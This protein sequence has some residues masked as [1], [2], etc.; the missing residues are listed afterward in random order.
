MLFLSLAS[1]LQLSK[2]TTADEGLTNHVF[3]AVSSIISKK[4]A[5]SLPDV[6][7]HGFLIMDITLDILVTLVY[8]VHRIPSSKTMVTIDLK[9]TY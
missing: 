9:N 8:D 1:W 7:Q 4:M 6:V 5:R 3:N 2:W